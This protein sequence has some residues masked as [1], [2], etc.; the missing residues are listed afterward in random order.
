MEYELERLVVGVFEQARVY[1]TDAAFQFG[2]ALLLL[3]VTQADVAAAVAV[4]DG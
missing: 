4:L 3:S 2:D 1:G